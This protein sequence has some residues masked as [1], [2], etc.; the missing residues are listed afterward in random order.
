[1]PF[2]FYFIDD[3]CQYWLNKANGTLGI[4]YSYYDFNMN[5]SWILN[6]D[7]GYYITLEI[8]YFSVNDKIQI[9]MPFLS[10]TFP[11]SIPHFYEHNLN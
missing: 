11:I 3:N 8:E 10:T 6:S 9:H 2:L 4:M 7:Q 5:C 1:M